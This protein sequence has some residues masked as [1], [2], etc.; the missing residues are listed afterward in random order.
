MDEL[1]DSGQPKALTDVQLALIQR[2]QERIRDPRKSTDMSKRN[3]T[4]VPSVV[5]L[6][7][8]LDAEKQL[9]FQL[10]EFLRQLYLRVGNGGFGPG[11]GL[12]AVVDGP[13]YPEHNLVQNY[14]EYMRSV[15]DDFP[16]PARYL[17]ICDWGCGFSSEID[18]TVPDAPVYRFDADLYDGGPCE[19]AI[20]PE[21]PS[22]HAWF[23]DWLVRPSLERFALSSERLVRYNRLI[24]LLPKL[25]NARIA[26]SR[27]VSPSPEKSWV[28]KFKERI[29][30]R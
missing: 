15:P 6:E 12:F 7:Q 10:P 9:G 22:L 8:L 5:T 16:W 1:S 19:S 27:T 3:P 30:K 13:Y 2:I 21:A 17:T 14:L 11:Y 25:A 26:G 18:W 4:V 28:T 20:V 23:E 29:L 24:D